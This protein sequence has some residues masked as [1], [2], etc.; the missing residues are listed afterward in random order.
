MTPRHF[1]PFAFALSLILLAAAAVTPAFAQQR[2]LDHDDALRWNRI[3][4]SA[5]SPDGAWLVYVLAAMEGDPVLA[6]KAARAGVD[7][8]TFRGTRPTF[9]SD[10]RFIVYS[11][12]PVEAVVDSLKR[13]GKRGDDLPDD[14]LGVITVDGAAGR[15]IGAVENFKVAAEGSWV[16]YTPVEEDEE[17][18]GEGMEE[19]GAGE[20]EAEP[21][22]E[23]EPEEEGEESEEKEEKKKDEGSPLVLLNLA[24]GEEVRYE[25]VT[26]YFFA[27]EAAVL[28]FA[29]SAK[30]GE[31]DGVFVVNLDDMAQHAVMEGKGNYEQLVVAEDGSQVAFLS[32]RD[33]YEADEP[34]FTL[35]RGAAPDWAG[36]TIANSATEG[37]PTGWWVSNSGNVSFS[38][39]GGRIHF[40][41]APRPETEEEDETLDEDKVTLDIWNWKDPYLQPMQLVQAGRERNRTYAAVAHLDGGRVVQLGTEAVPDVNFAADGDPPWAVGISN[42]PHRQLV[43]WD[44][45]YNDYYA[46]DVATGE[47]RLIAERTKGFASPSPSGNYVSWW[48]GAARHWMV[49]PLAGGDPVAASAGGPPRRLE[50]TGRPPRP[51]A[52]VRLGRLDRGRRGL[53]LLRSPRRLALRARHRR[54]H[55]RDWGRRPRRQHAFPLHAHRLRGP[56]S[57][58]GRGALG[59]LPLPEQ[60]VRLLPRAHR[61]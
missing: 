58:R 21:E 8:V 18:E 42:L 61:P 14:S 11:I 23:P 60:A 32:D 3:T 6:L 59:R 52:P 4:G 51:A 34:E 39:G 45:R 15:T 28:T 33:D 56:P 9:T 54:D 55:E 46:I 31:G 57:V 37:V 29:T 19:E 40:G 26:A 36:A 22:P 13:E 43:S 35:Y 7:E 41:T 5:L 47:A 44:G 20:P 25:K 17:E 38:D 48:D 2:A 1:R 12:P 27:A 53:P 16:A 10:S 24:T 49:A 50:R 30:D